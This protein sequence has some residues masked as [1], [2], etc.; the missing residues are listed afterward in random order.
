MLSTKIYF[1]VEET[2][3]NYPNEGF[4]VKVASASEVRIGLLEVR[5]GYVT[6]MDGKTL[7]K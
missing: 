7:F 6:G 3:F 4:L 1:E 2:I 5:F